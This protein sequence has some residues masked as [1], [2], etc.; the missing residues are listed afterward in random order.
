M[1]VDIDIEV[2][3]YLYF[4][5]CLYLIILYVMMFRDKSG[6]NFKACALYDALARIFL[7]MFV[8]Q[9]HG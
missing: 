7:I 3:R 6:I 9:F 2:R 5:Y 1:Y 4:S 8:Q